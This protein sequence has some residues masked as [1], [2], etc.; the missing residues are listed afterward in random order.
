VFCTS[1]GSA[2]TESMKFCGSCGQARQSQ[3]PPTAKPAEPSP[4]VT[5]AQAST[6]TVSP[7]SSEAQAGAG[8]KTKQRKT[9]GLLKS[10]KARAVAAGSAVFVIAGIASAG[11][12]FPSNLSNEKAEALLI[13]DTPL[14]YGLVMQPDWDDYDVKERRWL[15]FQPDSCQEDTEIRKIIRNDGQLLAGNFYKSN[16]GTETE[17]LIIEQNVLKMPS[18]ERAAEVL[19]L[20]TDGYWNDQCVY[21]DSNNEYG[22]YSYNLDLIT[23]PQSYGLG[24]SVKI[25]SFRV[26]NF[27][28][29]DPESTVNF[30]I[31]DGPY[32]VQFSVRDQNLLWYDQYVNKVAERVLEKV[33]S[34][35]TSLN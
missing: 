30:L 3:N 8:T 6:P 19:K 11:Y 31:A 25:V 26:S 13:G 32:L 4:Q 7:Q 29:D 27:G 16:R 10:G 35:R 12:L 28:D 21:N 2:F 33:Y 18:S 5:D 24:S 34:G 17:T 20:A 15:I 9:L 1:C 23:D 14:P 22:L